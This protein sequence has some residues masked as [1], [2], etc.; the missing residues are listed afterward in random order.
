MPDV[1]GEFISFTDGSD[2]EFAPVFNVKFQSDFVG[3]EEASVSTSDNVIVFPNTAATILYWN[4]VLDNGTIVEL[5]DIQG[6]IIKTVSA[7]D[8]N[9]IYVGDMDPGH[10]IFRCVQDDQVKTTSFIKK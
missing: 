9:Q 3:V 8:A 6:R 5:I 10:Y 7:L 4:S 2:E 1:S